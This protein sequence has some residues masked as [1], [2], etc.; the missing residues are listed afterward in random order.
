MPAVYL[1]RMVQNRR[2]YLP[3]W[4]LSD[5]GYGPAYLCGALEQFNSAVGIGGVVRI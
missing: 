5:N 1:A 3:F 4:T 2:I